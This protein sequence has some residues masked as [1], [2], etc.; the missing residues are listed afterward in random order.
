MNSVYYPSCSLCSNGKQCKKKVVQ[1]ADEA[2]TCAKCKVTFVDCVYKYI[3]QLKI[4]NH[5]GTLWAVSFDD[6]IGY[7]L[8]S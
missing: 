3:L 5:T 4:A 7:F 1:N 6:P 2:W 8:D